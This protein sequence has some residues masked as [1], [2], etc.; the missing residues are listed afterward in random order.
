MKEIF[1]FETSTVDNCVHV[2]EVWCKV[3]VAQQHHFA[4]HP[5]FEIKNLKEQNS[6]LS[7]Y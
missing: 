7:F 3:C 6:I 5:N 4:N 1:G 2:T